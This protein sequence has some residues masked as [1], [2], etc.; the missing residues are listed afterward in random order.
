MVVN[1]T[2]LVDGC[3]SYIYRQGVKSC[4]AP[5]WVTGKPERIE[6]K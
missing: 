4:L 5:V 3:V 6:T 2:G 1:T